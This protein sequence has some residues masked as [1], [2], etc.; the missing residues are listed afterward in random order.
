MIIDFHNHFYPETYLNELKR[1]KGYAS[2]ERDQHGRLLIHY[3]G[4]YNIVVGPH[5]DPEDRLKAM[6]LSLI[7]I[8]EPTRPY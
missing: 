1:R 8:S 7:H 3:A 4:D 5:V 2:V 6:D